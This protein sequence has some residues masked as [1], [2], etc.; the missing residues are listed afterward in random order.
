MPASTPRSGPKTTFPRRQWCWLKTTAIPPSKGA[1]GS[2]E[3]LR[4]LNYAGSPSEYVD[5]FRRYYGPTMNAFDAAEKNG[6]SDELRKELG[7]LR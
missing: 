2:F 3:I 5:L 4:T 6:R 1:H 7:K